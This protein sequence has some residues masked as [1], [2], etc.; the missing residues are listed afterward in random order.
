MGWEYFVFGNAFCVRKCIV[1]RRRKIMGTSYGETS[2]F[3]PVVGDDE[4]HFSVLP[5]VFNIL[6]SKK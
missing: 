4:N 1:K 3:S 2:G 5:I 6:W